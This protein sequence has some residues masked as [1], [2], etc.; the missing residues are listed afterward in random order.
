MT[1]NTKQST[2]ILKEVFL[3]IFFFFMSLVAIVIAVG[4]AN[5]LF[6]TF[7]CHPD[8]N[9]SWAGMNALFFL[10]KHAPVLLLFSLSIAYFGARVHAKSTMAFVLIFM[11]P[12]GLTHYSSLAAS[13]CK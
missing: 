10:E 11:I 3:W 1:G 5:E 9:N 2:E 8:S 6:F 4:A 13:Y 12:M 7:K